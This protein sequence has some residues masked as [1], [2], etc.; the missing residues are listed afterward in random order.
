MQKSDFQGNIGNFLSKGFNKSNSYFSNTSGSSGH[1]MSFAKD[2]FTHARVW[3]FWKIRYEE[4]GLNFKIPK[5]TIGNFSERLKDNIFN[6]KRFPVFDLSDEKMDGFISYFKNYSF[7][8]IYGYTS[9]I[10]YF[11]RYLIKKGILLSRVCPSLKLVIV[12][13]GLCK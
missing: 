7:D 8:Y 2:K 12:T 10:V 11:C 1:P 4:L 3:A 13:G 5:N 9:A 6:R